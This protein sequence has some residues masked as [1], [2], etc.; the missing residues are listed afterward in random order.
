M[1]RRLRL[2]WGSLFFAVMFVD[3]GASF[4]SYWLKESSTSRR[5]WEAMEINGKPVIYK[6]D[7]DATK[8]ELRTGDEIVS[9]KGPPSAA[10]PLLYQEEC[11]VPA[12]TSYTL[13]IRREGEN[14]ELAL[15]TSAV[16]L[17]DWL[18]DGAI[19]LILL[20]FLI[21]ALTV[22]L[23]KP[24]DQQAW[25]LALMLET[26][27]GIFQGFSFGLSGWLLYLAIVARVAGLAFLPIFFHFF[28]I[29]P[30][31]GPWLKRFPR[32][33]LL[34]YL[35]FLITILPYSGLRRIEAYLNIEGLADRLPAKNLLG[36]SA[37]IFVILYLV[38][39]LVAMATNY[40]EAN[41]I[42]RRK[43]RFVVAGCSAGILN[44][45]VLVL[46]EFLGI[47]RTNPQ[48]YD[49]IR[50]PLL[51]TLPLIPL[52]FA[53]AIIRHQ[54][55]PV[56][57]IIRRGLRYLLVSRGSIL[58]LMAGVSVLMF[59]VMDAFFSYLKPG[60]GRVVGV[61]S[62][63]IAI[64]V[65]HL[66]RAFHLRVVAPKVDRLF[67]HQAYDTQQIIADLAESLR[68]KTNLPQLLELV[69]TKIQS[70][71]HASNVKI[72]LRDEASGD[73]HCAY[74]C[75]YSF[76]NR[77]AV[78][79][80]CNATLQH[81]SIIVTRLAESGQ[82]IDLDSRAPQFDV[83]SENGSSGTL[84]SEERDALQKLESNLLLPIMGKEG[85][86]GVISLGPHL[87]DLP[88]SSEDKRLLKSVGGPTS[89]ALENVRLVERAIEEAR[90]RQELE[91]ENEQRAR[92]LD[93]AR[94]LQLSMLPKQVP[95]LPHLEIA[96]YMKT[97][98]EVGGDYYD[99]HLSDDGTL[100]VVVG[101]ATGH[102]LKAGTIV[103][104]TKSL[105]N[106][107][108]PGP[109][110]VDIFH[111]SSRALKQMNLRSLYMAMTMVKIKGYHLAL[112]SAG[113][114]PA[115]IYRAKTMT[116]DELTINGVPLACMTSYPYRQQEIELSC[117]DILVLMSDGFPERFNSKS[118]I[119]GYEKAREV[120]FE[121][122]DRSPR[123]IIDHFIKVSEE[124]AGGRPQNDD[125]TF[126]VLKAR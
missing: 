64:I 42:A 52:S 63:V 60:S 97:A 59:F 104:A 33:E 111:Q 9:L 27:V 94:Q 32:L 101:D 67:F 3:M 79:D 35:P 51:V 108:A 124:W 120:L 121:I 82:P 34:L 6:V 44:V 73:Y 118:E 31:R 4:Y 13:V 38:G 66:A 103:T 70:A 8:S 74:S 76:H 115:L 91:A 110:I 100:T 114:P 116:I 123:E 47:G 10:F 7:S 90:R 75:V 105:F 68:M 86:L 50:L 81:D 30:E 56:G 20:I 71:L 125:V 61:I 92:E 23:L 85:L 46:S 99:F 49:W 2:I 95:Q 1:K 117:G 109:D 55:I 39:G 112:S 107:L 43:L 78:Q 16:Q 14:R 40:R 18:V 48:L 29:F 80:P 54:V 69:A 17:S 102:G 5:G 96:E 11:D 53:Y 58:L 25:L 12:G 106:H 62:A 21:T 24:F 28:L 119:L 45:L 126:I 122:A 113:M 41:A 89:F 57:L 88:F 65:W 22:F 83:Q 19:N 93:E 87:G 84:S 26:F 36:L 37:M 98:T 77:S 15:K 72:L